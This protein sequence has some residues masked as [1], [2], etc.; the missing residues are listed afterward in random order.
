MPLGVHASIKEGFAGALK[1]AI[2]LG[3]ECVQFFSH[4]P[5]GWRMKRPEKEEIEKYHSIRKHTALDPVAIHCSYLVNIASPDATLY[6]RSITLLCKEVEM[7]RTL[8]ASY[9]VLHP[10]SSGREGKKMGIKRAVDAIKRVRKKMGMDVTILIENTAGSGTQIGRTLEDVALMVE[11]THNHNT[12]FC[13]DTAH[14]FS[15]G[16][17]MKNAEEVAGLSELME[18]TGLARALRLIHLNDSKAECGSL[19]DRHEHIGTGKIGP[20]GI[21]AILNAP[22]FKDIP[23]IL[24]TPRKHGLRDDVMNLNRAKEMIER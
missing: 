22:L 3:C 12:G 15:A 8:G 16:Y 14:G 13:F 5:R 10:G 4:N 23:F 1:E 24:E 9:L 20:E 6:E 11:L 2:K 7:A 17:S 19:A 21:R 18:R